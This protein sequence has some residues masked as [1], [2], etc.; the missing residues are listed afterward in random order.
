SSALTHGSNMRCASR[1]RPHR[2]RRLS[3]CLLSNDFGTREGRDMKRGEWKH[4]LAAPFGDV[5]EL[6]SQLWLEVPG[7][8]QYDVRPVLLDLGRIV[9]RDACPRSESTV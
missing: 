1:Y 8:C 3:Q 2:P 5:A 4:Q 7:Q 6:L 9:D